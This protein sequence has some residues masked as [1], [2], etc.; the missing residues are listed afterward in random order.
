MPSSPNSG[1]RPSAD[2]GP[3]SHTLMSIAAETCLFLR[4][5][6]YESGILSRTTQIRAS[7]QDVEDARYAA[8]IV[9]RN[10]VGMLRALEG[11]SALCVTIAEHGPEEPKQMLLPLPVKQL[12]AGHPSERGNDD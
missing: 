12:E 10:A 7:L 8:G 2:I 6:T 1:S 4:R 11:I 3:L 9:Y 5:L